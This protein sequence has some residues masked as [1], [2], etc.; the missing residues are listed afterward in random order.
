M[1]RRLCCS[2][3]AV[4]LCLCA[5]AFSQEASTHVK[6]SRS[7]DGR[8]QFAVPSTPDRYYV[9]YYRRARGDAAR[10]IPVAMRFGQ[11]GSTILIDQLA[12]GSAEGLYRVQPYPIDAAADHDGD[13]RSDSEELVDQTGLYAP[14]NPAAPIDFNDGV[15]RITSRQ[16]FRDLSYQGQ[17]VLIDTHL[18]SLEFVKFY[19]LDADTDHPQIYFM[20]TNTH[21]SHRSF[22]NAIGIPG[23]FGGGGGRGGGGR[24]PPGGGVPPVGFPLPD[25]TRVPPAGFPVPDSSFAPPLGGT[26]PPD[27]QQ[28]SAQMRGEIVYHPFL[29]GPN[30]E[31]GVYRF[32]FEPNDSY[33][34]ASVQMVY[35]LMAANMPI[36]RNNF[37][38]Y[39]MPNA[40]LPR[41]R[42]EKELF[43]ASRVAILLEEDIYGDI[44]F[45][46]LHIAEGYGVLRLMDLNERPNSRDIVIYEAL[47]NE[48]P[49]VGGVIT[50]VAQTPLSHVNLRAIQD[51]IPNAY[52]QNILEDEAVTALIGRY[53]YFRVDGDGYE[54]REATLEEVDAHYVDRRPS[55]AQ[56]PARN[57]AITEFQ[58]L[59][60]I[61]FGDSDA[62]G[63][64]AANMATLRSFGFAEGVVPNGFALPFYFYDEFMQHNGFYAKAAA[65]MADSDFQGDTATRDEALDAFRDQIKDGEMPEW[66]MTALEQLQDAFPEG[67][68]IRTRSSTNNEDLPG[69]SGAGLYDSF[70]HHPDE[71]HLS[72]S[73][74][75]VYAS[76]WNFRAFE[77][78]DF[79]RIDHFA[80]AMGV[81][82]HPNFSN[83]QANGVAVTDDPLY[84]TEG[85]FYL[86][87]QVGEDLVTNPEAQSIPEE[88]LVNARNSNDFTLVRS[89][90]Q[91]GDGE[92]ILSASYLREIHSLLNVIERNFRVLYGVTS[93]EQCAMEVEFKITA[94]GTLSIKQARPWVY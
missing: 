57:L 8:L 2:S 80:A 49:G 37:M 16:M 74:K 35:E 56:F 48:M 86:N 52:I 77:E 67:T 65:M 64:K 9:L 66:M 63:V 33:P 94:E 21:R 61:G 50:T 26:P 19:V 55:E 70:T 71:G 15:T 45:L 12:I 54:I 51:N 81:L 78:R 92:R 27:A 88:I 73:I 17:E 24:L 44:S 93:G 59:D 79:F 41:Y 82:L 75:Q 72:K 31:A 91:V 29:K 47:P 25:S 62:F 87:T 69:F 46:P 36:L 23:G 32:E 85:N 5:V 18:E 1:S 28:T 34:F 43:D 14:L 4:L 38:Y 11:V 58:A 53:V 40:A 13:G 60:A 39:P 84:Q 42:Q 90:N 22:A 20:N 7:S 89:S 68:S 3:F 83:E 10:E 76:L 6:I 30:G